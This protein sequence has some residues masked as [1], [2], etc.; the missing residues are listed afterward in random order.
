[1]N[2]KN[3]TQRLDLNLLRVFHRVYLDRSVTLAAERLGLTQSAVSHGVRK[4]RENF[5]DELFVRSRT[6]VAPTAKADNLFGS[7]ELIMST[8]Q[9]ELLPAAAFDATAARRNFRLSM[10]DMAEVTFLRP[11]LERARSRGWKTTFTSRRISNDDVERTLETG[12]TELAIGIFP[13][14]PRNYYRQTLF[15][16]DSVVLAWKDHPRIK[17]RLTWA[18]FE[19]EEHIVV[20]SGSDFFLQKYTLEPLG[21]RR[22][23]H[24]T[25]DGFLSIPWLLK[26][27]DLLATVPMH[28]AKGIAQ[29]AM[30]KQLALPQ[31]ARAYS[32]QSMW[33]PQL[34]NDPGH[35]WLRETIYELVNSA[36]G[37]VIFDR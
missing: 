30:V 28:L 19:R 2:R 4:L 3:V 34:H 5:N 12:E 13:Q 24:L 11:L 9:T 32:L 31:S 6:G 8:L 1:M 22:K 10:N 16:H 27:T 20:A 21:I 36:P 23:A 7:V 15:A 35:R 33:H 14:A 25:V 29:A 26:G 37:D 18:S 17:T